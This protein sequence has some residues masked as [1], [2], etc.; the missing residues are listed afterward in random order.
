MQIMRAGQPCANTIGHLCSDTSAA[1]N[2]AQPLGRDAGIAPKTAEEMR[3]PHGP[4]LWG[5]LGNTFGHWNMSPRELLDKI[6][7]LA[8]PQGEHF[9][10]GHELKNSVAL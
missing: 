9:D 3:K 8:I 2:G 4:A 1:R 6:A 5:G 7:L 10:Q